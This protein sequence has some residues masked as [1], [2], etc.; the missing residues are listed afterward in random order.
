MKRPA[1]FIKSILR[2][3]SALRIVYARFATN[4]LKIFTAQEIMYWVATSMSLTPMWC[5][6]WWYIDENWWGHKYW[7]N[8]SMP[9]LPENLYRGSKPWYDLSK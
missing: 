8:E 6:Q 9:V 3:V 7:L 2:I 1:Q 4:V 5:E